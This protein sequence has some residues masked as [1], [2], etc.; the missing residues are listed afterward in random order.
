MKFSPERFAFDRV[1]RVIPI[2]FYQSALRLS[3]LRPCRMLD[4]SR[5]VWSG[6]WTCHA[7]NE[8]CVIS[9]DGCYRYQEPSVPCQHAWCV[10]ALGLLE[11]N[12]WVYSAHCS[13]RLLMREEAW[14]M[15][16]DRWIIWWG[17]SNHCDTIRN[18]LHFI[19]DMCGLDIVP[20]R[21][22]TNITNPRDPSQ[23]VPFTSIFNGHPNDTGNYQ[24]LNLLNNVEY[25]RLLRGYFEGQVVPNT[26]V[27][28]SGLHYGV[29][30]SNVTRFITGEVYAAIFWA[31]VMEGVESKGLDRPMVIHQTTV[32]MGGYA[33]RLAF[34]PHKMEAC[35]GIVLDKLRRYQVVD[36]IIDDLT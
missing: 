1:L 18:I 29:Y 21:F 32:A 14:S 34:N 4:Y 19:M 26:I 3:E 25:R 6:Q 5:E 15:L 28:N 23:V 33:R 8:N 12:R 24:G 9:N 36:R 30:W 27:M 2:R 16:R 20:R 22:D 17:D 10:V 31:S 11:S 35:N 7:K 13:F